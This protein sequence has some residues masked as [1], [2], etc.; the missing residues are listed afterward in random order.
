MGVTEGKTKE[1]EDR[2]TALL[3]Q[4]KVITDGQLK[5]ALDYQRSLGGQLSDILVKL[6][7]VRA[8]QIEECM[9]KLDEPGAVDA[10][11]KGNPNVLDPNDFKVS[12]LKVHRRLLDKIPKQLVD[13]HLLVPFF[14]THSV[15]SR[16][17]ILGHGHELRKA[18]EEKVRTIVGVELCTL[19]LPEKVAREILEENHR[20]GES[21]PRKPPVA[22][23]AFRSVR[24]PGVADEV[25]LDA[26]LNV[27]AKRGVVTAEELQLE[28]EHLQ[29]G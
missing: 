18:I 3:I 22:K 11:E 9:E 27:L 7:L 17:I 28:A 23:P 4:K 10:D 15:D 8:S 6:D 20:G 24:P 2:L 5:A 16:K 12:E 14:P 19:E 29:G 1:G 13:A 25:V 21:H 26:L